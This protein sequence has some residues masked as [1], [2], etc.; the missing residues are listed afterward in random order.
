MPPA[1][2]SPYGSGIAS[3]SRSSAR[4][5][6][7]TIGTTSCGFVALSI[8][9]TC[10]FRAVPPFQ[11]DINEVSS[12]HF[13]RRRLARCLGRELLARVPYRQWTFGPSISCTPL[14]LRSVN[15]AGSR[16]TRMYVIDGVPCAPGANHFTKVDT[17]KK[18]IFSYPALGQ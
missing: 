9:G 14:R 7:T 6:A 8:S 12:P 4:F 13:C 17:A 1:A 15:S 11:D 18:H 2:P 10:G 3:H 5:Q 16:R